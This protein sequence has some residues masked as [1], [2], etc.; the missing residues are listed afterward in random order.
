MRVNDG[1]RHMDMVHYARPEAVFYSSRSIGDNE[2]EDV[3]I[4]VGH[5][6]EDNVMLIDEWHRLPGRRFGRATAPTRSRDTMATTRT[7]SCF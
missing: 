4:Y 3:M 2:E 7:P 6:E 5:V 1:E